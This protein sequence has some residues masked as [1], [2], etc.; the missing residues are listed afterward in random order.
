M[1][2]LVIEDYLAGSFR[3]IN[4]KFNTEQISIRQN[5]T[6]WTWNHV[7]FNPD[8]VMANATYIWS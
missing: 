8:L 4:S 3:V 7:E 6:N 2:N 5:Q 1:S